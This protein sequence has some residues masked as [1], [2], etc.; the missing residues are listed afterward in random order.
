VAATNERPVNNNA[1][2]VRMGGPRGGQIPVGKLP[3]LNKGPFRRVMGYF[4]RFKL[5]VAIVVLCIAISAFV[6]AYGSMFIRTVIDDY[7]T[8]LI[9]SANPDYSG[10]A[11]RILIM[12]GIYAVGVLSTFIYHRAMIPVSQGIQ[13]SRFR[14]DMFSECRS[15]PSVISIHTPSAIP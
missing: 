5:R 4:G 3:T 10:L 14:D 13:K 15:C 9:G 1:R 7:I 6:T 12:V 2:G 8:P 11:R